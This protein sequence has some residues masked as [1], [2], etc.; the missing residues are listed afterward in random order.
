MRYWLIAEPVGCGSEPVWKIYSEEAII[1][2][3]W[4]YWQQKGVAYNKANGLDRNEGITTHR[5]IDDWVV[6]NWA[7]RATPETLLKIIGAP[8]QQNSES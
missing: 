6:V 2:E 5:C 7:I 4:N 3:Y 8:K 1:E